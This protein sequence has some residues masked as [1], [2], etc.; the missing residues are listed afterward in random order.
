MLTVDR[1]KNITISS[2]ISQAHNSQLVAPGIALHGD[3]STSQGRPERAAQRYK[4]SE[5]IAECRSKALHEGRSFPL[6]SLLITELFLIV[7][8]AGCSCSSDPSGCTSWRER[9][10]LLRHF[11]KPIAG[12]PNLFDLP[13]KE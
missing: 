8:F 3:T 11:V 1:Q 6:E 12:G 7:I 13:K 2:E 9:P 4:L 5:C 10:H